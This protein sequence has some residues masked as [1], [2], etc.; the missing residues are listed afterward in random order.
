MKKLVVFLIIL[1]IVAGIAY[2]GI[3][4][5]LNK[6]AQSF[7]P[8]A[9]SILAERD[10][11]LEQLEFEKIQYLPFKTLH[12]H[13]VNAQLTLN[14]RIRQQNALPFQFAVEKISLLFTDF[15]DPHAILTLDGFD[16]DVNRVDNQEISRLGEIRQAY[17]RQN[18]PVSLTSP[19]ESLQRM[20]A[21]AT[22]L[23]TETN[24]KADIDFQG[25]VTLMIADKP[26]EIRLYTISKS[27]YSAL[28]MD[29]HD[30]QRVVDAH[31]L[32]PAPREVQIICT[33]PTRAAKIIEI[34]E[35]AKIVSKQA[36]QNDASVPEDAYRHVLWSYLLTKA[37]SPEFAQ[38]ITDAHE[39]LPGNTREER[40]MDFHNNEVGRQFAQ[41]GISEKGILYRVKTDQRVIRHPDNVKDF[42]SNF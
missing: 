24:V 2:V 31:N 33:F 36:H 9:Q 5:A 26:A 39:T 42:Y 30:M 35:Y 1:A 3:N 7:L 13:H 32:E 18:T 22:A 16:I 25:Q 37:F 12:I 41:S 15:K 19:G 34:T 10:V 40:K 21:N 29:E 38:R 4:F 11:A 27:G 28:R 6:A 17:W 23:F 8:Q 20:L 14:K